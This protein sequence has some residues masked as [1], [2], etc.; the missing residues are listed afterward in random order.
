MTTHPDL[1]RAAEKV[2]DFCCDCTC[3]ECRKYEVESVERILRTELA[4]VLEDVERLEFSMKVQGITRAT[5][6]A[7]RKG[8]EGE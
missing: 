3:E 4:E 7:A 5:I 2:R 8:G 1:R 6:D